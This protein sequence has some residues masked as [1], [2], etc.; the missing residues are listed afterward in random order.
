VT[1]DPERETA[2]R[3]EIDLYR[4]G[5][6]PRDLARRAPRTERARVAVLALIGGTTSSASA[7]LEV[8]RVDIVPL[9]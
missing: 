9:Q 3:I 4:T 5:G 7:L 1:F 2:A 8:A 6:E